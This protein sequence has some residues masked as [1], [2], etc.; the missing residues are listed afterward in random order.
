MCRLLEWTGL[1]QWKALLRQRM[2]PLPRPS[3]R[4]L[5]VFLGMV[6]LPKILRL[7]TCPTPARKLLQEVS[8]MLRPSAILHHEPK[9]QI[10]NRLLNI[11]RLRKYGAV[12]MLPT[13]I[14]ANKDRIRTRT[15]VHEAPGGMSLPPQPP[16]PLLNH[17]HQD[18][19]FPTKSKHP[20][21]L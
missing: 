13:R 19:D 18:M 20:L 7:N 2:N 10:P 12:L 1:R 15:V 21:H 17:P 9:P 14:T 11:N 4:N 6:L 3:T 5:L 8:G 16:R